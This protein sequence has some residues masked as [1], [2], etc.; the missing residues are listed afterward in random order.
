MVSAG[1]PN[2][3]CVFNFNPLT[4]AAA[5]DK[6]RSPTSLTTSGL[7]PNSLD[8]STFSNVTFALCFLA[9]WTAFSRAFSAL[10]EPSTATRIFESLIFCLAIRTGHSAWRETFSAMLPKEKASTSVS[11]RLPITIKS[12]SSSLAAR[13]TVSAGSSCSI[14]LASTST[15][16]SLNKASASQ[17]IFLPAWENQFEISERTEEG[18]L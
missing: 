1:L 4:L 15:P 6:T 2:S 9:S 16:S 17:T 8:S 13:R 14:T 11:P 18:T 12:Y 5:S 10:S 3:S 7:K